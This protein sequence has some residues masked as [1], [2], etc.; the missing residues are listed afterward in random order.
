MLE[1]VLYFINILK[2]AVSARRSCHQTQRLLY[3]CAEISLSAIFV[4]GSARLDFVPW[5]QGALATLLILTLLVL[6]V[7]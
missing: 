7:V 3:F 2:I 4:S 1:N 6:K 5:R